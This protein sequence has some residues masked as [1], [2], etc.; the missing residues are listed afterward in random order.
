MGRPYTIRQC[1]IDSSFYAFLLL[2]LLSRQVSNALPN[3]P[4][5]IMLSTGLFFAALYN[6]FLFLKSFAG[7]R[8]SIQQYQEWKQNR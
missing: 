6:L 4:F 5:G 7:K 1:L 3:N 2:G 8:L